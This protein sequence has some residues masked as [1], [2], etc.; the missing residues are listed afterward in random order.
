MSRIDIDARTLL[1]ERRQA[2]RHPRRALARAQ[3][4]GAWEEWGGDAEPLAAEARRELHEIEAA[5][6]RIEEGRYG[7]CQACGGPM[8]LQ[9]LRA[10]PEARYCLACSGNHHADD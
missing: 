7:I 1:Q 3:G 5:L 2:L 10:I 6:S 4:G 9:R 8:G